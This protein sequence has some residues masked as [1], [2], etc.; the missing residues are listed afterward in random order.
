MVPVA[1]FEFHHRDA[2]SKEFAISAD[3]VQRRWERIV[4]E[5]DK[6]VLVC[7]NCHREIHAGVRELPGGGPA[8]LAE[9][10]GRY[11]SG[12]DAVLRPFTTAV[13]RMPVSAW[14]STSV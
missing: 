1:A 9:R 4:A 5:L 12:P 14:S 2:G 11:C 8:G 13:Q 6:C 3:G 7:A 10:S